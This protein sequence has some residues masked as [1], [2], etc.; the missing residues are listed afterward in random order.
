[1]KI[2]KRLIKNKQVSDMVRETIDEKRRMKKATGRSIILQ[3][4]TDHFQFFCPT[5]GTRLI[6]FDAGFLEDEKRITICDNFDMMAGTLRLHLSCLEC[7]EYFYEKINMNLPSPQAYFG[8]D[9][10]KK[11]GSKRSLSEIAEQDSVQ[12]VER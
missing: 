12:E 11:I 2:T 7:R 3:D 4:N 10:D 9:I 6:V 5:C 8:M 1:M